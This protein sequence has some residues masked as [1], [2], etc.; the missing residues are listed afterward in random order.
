MA[1]VTG[2]F[3]ADFSSFFD[4]VQ[5]SELHLKDLEQ[6]A[7]KVERGLGRMADSFSG[8]KIIQDAAEMSRILDEA[9]G[10]SA[11]TTKELERMGAT[12]S[13]AVA[14]LKALGQDVPPGI[15]RIADAATNATKKQE[16]LLNSIGASGGRVNEFG[17]AIGGASSKVSTLT[18]QYQQ[19][20]GVLQA[21]GVNIGP[22]VKGLEDIS[23]AAGKTAS[24]LGVL[25]TAGLAA[26]AFMTGWKIGKFIDDMTGASTAVENLARSFMGLEP[27]MTKAETQQLTIN[28]AIDMGAAAGIKYADAIKF[29]EAQTQKNADAHIN[30]TQR[31]ADAHKEV[32]GLSDARKAEIAIAV[33]AGAT[34]E[35]LTNK[36]GLSATALGL[37]ATETDKATAAQAKLNAERAKELA[38][39]DRRNKANEEGIAL[40]NR[41]AALIADRAKFDAEQLEIQNKKLAAGAGYVKQ[42]GEV[43]RVNKEAADFEKNLIDQQTKLD[44]ENKKLITSFTGAGKA[45]KEAGTQ[46]KE[47][48]TEAAIAQAGYVTQIELTSDGIKGWLEL[49]QYTNAANAILNQNSLFTSTSQLDQ[50]VRMAGAFTGV[51]P[52]P[53]FAGGVTNFRGGLARVHEGELLTNL[54]RGTS[55]IPAGA[56]AG[57][58]NM[59]NVFNLVDSESN[60]AR[61]VSEMIMRTIR[62]GTQLSSA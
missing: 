25:G 40:M 41:D 52:I 45:A 44:E 11:F 46:G 38:D 62:A 18:S 6:D 34:T 59:S 43:A 32:R 3:N 24:Q 10:A 9:G 27:A 21:A 58:V 16:E 57:G 42:M 22:Q 49:M 54:P 31:L 13:E 56:G 20:D 26:G 1:A 2:V 51:M 12:G 7:A 28:K 23:N 47:G 4:A 36:Y 19:F 8:R 35:Q 17:T 30:W 37:L 14:K 61:K 5:K 29:I 15:Q 53:G 33:E 55:V 39:K 50:L 48:A 60:L